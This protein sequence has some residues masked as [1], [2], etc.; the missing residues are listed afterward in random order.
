MPE[1]DCTCAPHVWVFPAALK[2]LAW[3][4]RGAPSID[5]SPNCAVVLGRCGMFEEVLKPELPLPSSKR[6]APSPYQ[7]TFH[8]PY[9]SSSDP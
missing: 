3:D 7:L 4:I 2:L 8:L 6:L 1:F 9:Y 5:C